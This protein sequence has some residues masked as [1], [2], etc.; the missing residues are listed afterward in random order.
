MYNKWIFTVVRSYLGSSRSECLFLLPPSLP[1][2]VAGS[3]TMAAQ[4]WLNHDYEMDEGLTWSATAPASGPGH[5]ANP[6][7]VANPTIASTIVP[8]SQWT[9]GC[10]LLATAPADTI[11]PR[12]LRPH[13]LTR[14]KRRAKALTAMQGRA[15]KNGCSISG[16]CN[17]CTSGLF[18]P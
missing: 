10:D 3:S 14:A 17:H 11:L 7:H 18:L 16:Y 15:A 2:F 5:A 4:A 1:S 6:I 13:R 12:A 8:G 9:D